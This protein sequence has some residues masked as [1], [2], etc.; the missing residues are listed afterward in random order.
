MLA[1]TA[2]GT[3]TQAQ[4]SGESD[5]KAKRNK[6]IELFKQDK[7]LEALPFFED[8][9]QQNAKDDFVLLGLATCL[10]SHAATIEDEAA[11]AKERIRARELLLNAKELGND[12]SLLHNL[13]EMLPPDGAIPYANTPAEQAM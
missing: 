13:L 11:A 3:P 12:S 6:A 8:L 1:V 9:A 2:S 7:H 10:V 4:A 5:Y